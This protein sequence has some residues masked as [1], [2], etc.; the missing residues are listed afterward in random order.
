[1]IASGLDTQDYE[2]SLLTFSL[3]SIFQM[4]P[5]TFSITFDNEQS[6]LVISKVRFQRLFSRR[7]LKSITA[8]YRS[9]S[10]GA[11]SPKF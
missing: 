10:A 7:M 11:V 3:N 5:I 4:K 9:E 2:F 8:Q 6:C 1:M